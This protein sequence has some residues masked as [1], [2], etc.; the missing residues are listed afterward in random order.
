M[1]RALHFAGDYKSKGHLLMPP[2]FN[3][4]VSFLASDFKYRSARIFE[5]FEVREFSRIE[6]NS[7]FDFGVSN[8]W[9]IRFDKIREFRTGSRTNS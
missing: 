5:Q 9:P 2:T 8:I 3:G 6:S 1:A 7:N 4:P